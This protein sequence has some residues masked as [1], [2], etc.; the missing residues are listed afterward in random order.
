[1]RVNSAGV[2]KPATYS[3]QR[4]QHFQFIALPGAIG[5][6]Q[7]AATRRSACFMLAV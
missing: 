4:D 6:P 5:D 7:S 1:M 2:G 3:N